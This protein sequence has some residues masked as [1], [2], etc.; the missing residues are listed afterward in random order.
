MKQRI[1][2]AAKRASSNPIV[3][4]SAQSLKPS[5]TVWGVLGIILFFILPEII[6][7]IWGEEIAQWAHAHTVTEPT[8]VE[9]RIYWVLEKLFE[10]G[11]SWANLGIGIAL[12]G[13]LSWDWIRVSKEKPSQ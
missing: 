4:K 10:D 1:K 9:R 5:R 8:E 12:L 6:A 2:D 11:G 7:F 13:W 3:Q